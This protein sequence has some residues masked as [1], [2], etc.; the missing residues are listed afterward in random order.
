MFDP[1]A[2]PPKHAAVVAFVTGLLLLTGTSSSQPLRTDPAGQAA[3]PQSVEEA[4]G[5]KIGEERRYVLEPKKSL[6]G[7]EEAWW[8]IRL[9]GIEGEGE[10]LRI[11]FELEHQRDEITTGNLFAING[12]MQSVRVEGRLTVNRFGFPERL[13]M[14]EQHHL[15]GE[16]GGQSEIRTT[17]FRFDGEQY[18]KQVR[19]GGREWSFEIPIATN[20][21]LDLAGHTGL[22]LFMPSALNCLGGRSRPGQPRQCSEGEVAFANPGLLSIVLPIFWEEQ[23]NEREFFFFRPRGVGTV[24]TL[25]M[26]MGSWA[27]SERDQLRNLS[28]YYERT[29][30]EFEEY[31]EVEIGSRTVDAWQLD[32][33]GSMREFW[34]DN[35]GTV[36]KLLLDPH[37]YT[38]GERWIRLLYP[39]EY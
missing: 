15:A 14:Q 7:G 29:R 38:R 31:V 34:V 30:F 16:L 17:I 28:R 21:N 4:F 25:F 19:I 11:I 5:F 22:Y 33:S 18:V 8:T 23:V 12:Q 1:R 39:S 13:V 24:S 3:R 9:D 36:L 10:A 2:Q 6:R 26:N 20:D 35:D 32:A 27:R 37:P